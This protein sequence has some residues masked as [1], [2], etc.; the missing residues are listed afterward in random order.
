[1]ERAKLFHHRLVQQIAWPSEFTILLDCKCFQQK[2]ECKCIPKQS[3]LYKFDPFMH[4]RDGVL[5]IRLRRASRGNWIDQT[6][7]WNED[8]DPP[9]E[10]D[11]SEVPAALYAH[12]TKSRENT[13]GKLQ[14]EGDYHIIL[15]DN[16]KWTQM[17][18]LYLHYYHLCA[19]PDNTLFTARNQDLWFMKGVKF[20]EKTLKSCQNC[21]KEWA[22]PILAKMAP[23]PFFRMHASMAYLYIQVDIMGPYFI[24]NHFHL[25]K[26]IKNKV[27]IK[28]WV[29]VSSCLFTRHMHF[30]IVLSLDTTAMINAVYSIGRT[31]GYPVYIKSDL[32][33]SFIM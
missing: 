19:T 26:P 18:I 20:V 10:S 15:P 21:K 12:P 17:I 13:E 1:M 27:P 22:K 4:R 9:S 23:L 8:T 7:P 25:T 5:R 6:S 28:C 33:S 14:M 31:F 11:D 32:Q 16:S 3:P 29:L 30:K 2:L 24:F